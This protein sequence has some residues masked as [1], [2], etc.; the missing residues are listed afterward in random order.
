MMA[1]PPRFHCAQLQ[2]RLPSLSPVGKKR[3]EALVGEWMSGEVSEY[4]WWYGRDIRACDRRL[5]DM[6]WSAN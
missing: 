6:E 4:R 5:F 3:L 1:F 2:D